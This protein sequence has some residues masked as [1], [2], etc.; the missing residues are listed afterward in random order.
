MTLFE[1]IIT[2]V[3]YL[4]LLSAKFSLPIISLKWTLYNY[5][6]P[7]LYNY[8]LPT[9]YNYL[10]P[11]LYNYLLFGLIN[12]FR[13]IF[14]YLITEACDGRTEKHVSFYNL[15]DYN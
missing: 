10:L 1:F 13:S 15:E 5:L 4:K 11:T 8:L 2:S 12:I 3:K 7:T 9:L 14:Y 6:L